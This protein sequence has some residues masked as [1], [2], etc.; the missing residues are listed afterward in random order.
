M[1]PCLATASAG[2]R[3]G[4]PSTTPPSSVWR[5]SANRRLESGSAKPR[6]CL[7]AQTS[8]SEQH[9]R[10]YTAASHL[11]EEMRLRLKKSLPV[12]IEEGIQVHEAP[13]ASNGRSEDRLVPKL[14]S[15]RFPA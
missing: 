14:R 7:A 13:P 1:P 10:A 5:L 9:D 11:V 6:E 8:S 4:S 12:L 2:D 15:S 3:T